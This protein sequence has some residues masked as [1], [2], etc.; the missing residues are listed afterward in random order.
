MARWCVFISIF[1]WVVH[2][3]LLLTSMVPFISYTAQLKINLRP[4]WS[5][6]AEALASI[7]ERKGF[8]DV[9]WGYVF[10]ELKNASRPGASFEED[11]EGWLGEDGEEEELDDVNESERTWRDPSAH[12]LRCV[13]NAW[14]RGRAAQK[15]IREVFALTVP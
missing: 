2:I 12:K 5:P 4:L 3:N 13:T 8:G 7:S 9:V 1:F 10:E 15:A 14:I 6:T 11:G